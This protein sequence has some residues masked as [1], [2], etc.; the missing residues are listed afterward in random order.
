MVARENPVVGG[1]VA[2]ALVAAGLAAQVPTLPSEVILGLLVGLG[3]L[4]PL[5]VTEHLLSK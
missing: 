4:A 2:L 3:V 1:F 5:L